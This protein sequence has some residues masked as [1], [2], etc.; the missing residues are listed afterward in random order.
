MTIEEALEVFRELGILVLPT[1]IDG[2]FF[3]TGED[4]EVEV[5]RQEEVISGALEIQQSGQTASGS[6]GG[7]QATAPQW[8]PA[9][10]PWP[11]KRTVRVG[12]DESTGDPIFGEA[13]DY[14]TYS[15]YFQRFAPFQESF[16]GFTR[17]EAEAQAASFGSGYEPFY[18]SGADRWFVR[19]V[20][21]RPPESQGTVVEIEGR[22]FIQQPDGSLQLM[23]EE[24]RRTL[25][26]QIEKYIL[27]GEVDQALYLDFIRDQVEQKR[28]SILDA[29]NLAAPVAQNPQHLQELMQGLMTQVGQSMEESQFQKYLAQFAPMTQE[30]P[31][32][33]VLELPTQD[34]GLGIGDLPG[35]GPGV[36]DPS[37]PGPG[38]GLGIGDPSGSGLGVIGPFSP[39]PGLGLPLSEQRSSSKLSQGGV[40]RG[41]ADGPASPVLS[42]LTLS[43]LQ[44]QPS[45]NGLGEE[46]PGGNA[47]LDPL[48]GPIPNTLRA[49]FGRSDAK[50]NRGQRTENE[51]DELTNLLWQQ[52]EASKRGVGTPS[53][54]QQRISRAVA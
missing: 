26:E 32:K 44:F 7:Q 29:F 20:A 51:E 2:W 15:S 45:G 50:R 23:S 30:G 31:P 27:S 48:G 41:S 34:S 47:G 54:A 13:F 38:P 43:S 37:F 39:S 25:D 14:D 8:W 9:N 40:F 36:I 17:A 11:P 10:V 1:S 42:P 24:P 5:Y 49:Y 19:Q 18:D 16:G 22:Q 33:S 28:F 4:G 46:L 35:P 21:S 52:G 12:T 6:V 3:V 53:P